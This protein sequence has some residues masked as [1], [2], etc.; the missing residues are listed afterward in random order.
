MNTR[1]PIGTLIALRYRLL[2]AQART[3]A[4]RVM[5]FFIV[6]LL[7]AF[8]FLL[9]TLG[10]LGAA[11]AAVRSG[12][13]ELVVGGILG[14]LFAAAV[15]TTLFMSVGPTSAFSDRSLRRFP[16]TERARFLVRHFIGLLDP[17]WLLWGGLLLGLAAGLQIVSACPLYLG[18]PGMF[19]YLAVMY[20]F[21]AVLVSLVGKIL[22]TRS[23]PLILMVFTMLI[24][25]SAVMGGPMAAA[26]GAKLLPIL[27]GALQFTPAAAAAHLLVGATLGIRLAGAGLLIAWALAGATLLR[28][29]EP[30]HFTRR[31][32]AVAGATGESW[33]DAVGDWFGADLGP[34]VAKSL[35]Y[36][37]R[38]NRVRYTLAFSTPVFLV[39]MFLQHHDPV[40]RTV[41]LLMVLF[42]IGFTATNPMSVNALGWDGPG[43]RR[44]VLVP[45]SADGAVRANSYAGMMLGGTVAMLALAFVIAISALPRT[46]EL[47]AFA[48]AAPAAGLFWL[49]TL[50]VWLTVLA[51]RPAS[52][53]AM[54][55]G[56]VSRF[57]GLMM[58]AIIVPIFILVPFAARAPQ[59]VISLGWMVALL[60]AIGFVAYRISLRA[61]G[62]R[63][64]LRFEKIVG[65]LAAKSG[66]AA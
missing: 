27:L 21:V 14:G 12:Q 15:P 4:G 34:L 42:I 28:L 8:F 6:Y 9:L 61:A 29:I 33:Y 1:P 58:A 64:A 65:D 44:Y 23:G 43:V 40:E 25:L 11:V 53:D 52:F 56:N 7:G 24:Y 16:L 59:F 63:L 36:H 32:E 18:I 10:G 26:H 46:W 2:W 49:H 62:A 20:L 66:T 39:I 22:E 5:I 55:S 57:A 17:L 41:G 30:F 31:R 37:L 60:A 50:G 13:A 45:A 38:C 51:P 3:S 54:M 19:A 35:R 47:V 48:I